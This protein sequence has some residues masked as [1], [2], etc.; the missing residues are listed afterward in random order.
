MTEDRF[1]YR[2]RQLLNH[3]LKDMPPTATRRLEAARHLA[4]AKQKQPATQMLLAGIG[5]KVLKS[6][7]RT[8]HLKQILSILALLLGM[9]LSFYWHSVQ[10]VTEL[11]DVDSA[12]LADDLPP[13][14]FLDNDFFKWLLDDSSDD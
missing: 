5:S 2:V 14:A 12:L 9:W 6:G 11:Q 8:P 4:L 3:G 1:A 7:N 13:E 10:Y